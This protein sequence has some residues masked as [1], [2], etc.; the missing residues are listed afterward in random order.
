MQRAARFVFRAS[1]S[2]C[3]SGHGCLFELEALAAKQPE[4]VRD[5]GCR[6]DALR[7]LKALTLSKGDSLRAHSDFVAT[8]TRLRG[9]A[10][11]SV[12]IGSRAYHKVI[13]PKPPGSNP[14]HALRV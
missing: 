8:V 6:F 13:C 2:R 4:S 9:I 5:R 12:A 11:R 7:L 3:E 14:K 1:P 10:A